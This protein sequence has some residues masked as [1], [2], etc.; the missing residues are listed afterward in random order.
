MSFFKIYALIMKEILHFNLAKQ[1]R[2]L[3]AFSLF[4]MLGL[5]ANAQVVAT[6]EATNPT[7]GGFTNGSITAIG[8]GG[9]APYTYEWS[10]GETTESIYGLG[11]GT[12]SVTITDMDLGYDVATVTLT[13]APQTDADIIISDICSGNGNVTVPTSGGVPPYVY[14]WSD[15]GSGDT[16]TGLLAGTQYC[17]T[18]LDANVCGVVTCVVIPEAINLT[19]V[20]SDIACSAG[21]D[22]S[23]TAI[24]TGGTAPYDVLWD[25]GETS[26]VNA[27]LPV[28]TYFVT[29]TDGNGC[30]VSGSGTVGSPSAIDLAVSVTSPPCGDNTMG[31]AS[32][33]P[34]GGT[35]NYSY[36]WSTGATTQS[37]SGLSAGTY[38]VTV[39]DSQGCQASTDVVIE[40]SSQVD[41]SINSNNP[42]CAAPN[43]GSATATGSNGTAPYTYEWNTGATTQTITN[44]GAGLYTVMVTD[45]T[46][47]TNAA[48]VTLTQEGA[49]IFASTTQVNASCGANNGSATAQGSGGS[50]SYSYS[51]SNG[52]NTQTISNLAPGTYTVTV[53]DNNSGCMGAKTIFITGTDDVDVFVSTMN[54]LCSSNNGNAMASPS[55]GTAPYTYA[56]SNGGNTQVITGLAPGTYTVTVTDANGCTAVDSDT[57]GQTGSDVNVTAMATPVS[58]FGENTG[59][60]GT[61][62]SGGATPYSFSWS[63]GATSSTLSNLTAGTYNVTVT[64]ANGCTATASATVIQP[65]QLNV[66]ASST[67]VACAGGNTGSASANVTGGTSGYSYS[68][69][70][71]GNTQTISNLSA[72][73]YTVTVTDANGCT[74]TSSTT[75]GQGG[76]ITLSPGSTD[77]SC[78]GGNDGTA[79]VNAFGGTSPYNYAWSNGG[80]SQM[81]TGLSA[82]TY[83][84]TVTDVNG[85]TATA[86]TTISQPTQ[87]NV[88]ANSTASACAGANTGTAT[89]SSSGGSAPYTYAWSNGG[90]GAT[91]TGLSAGTYTVTATDSNG[92][93]DTSSTTVSQGNGINVNA[94]STASACAGAS[95]GTAT[96]NA[97]GGS[98]PYTYAWSNGGNNATITGLSAGTYTVTVTDANG[99][100]NIDATTVTQG[101]DLDVTTNATTVSCPGGINGTAT[102]NASGGSSPY[103]Y[104]W[105]NGGSGSSISG[106]TNGTYTVTATDANGCTGVSTATVGVSNNPSLSCSVTVSSP[107]SENNGSD[108]ALTVAVSNGSGNYS[109]AWSNGA[110]AQNIN[111]LSPGTYTVTVTDNTTG[112]TTTCS[113]TLA[114]PPECECDNFTDP[115][116]IC[117]DQTACGT[118]YDPAPIT[119]LVNPSGGSGGPI[120]Y[121]WMFKEGEGPFN[122][123]QVT[124]I[125]NT[126]SLTYDPPA[127]YTTTTYYRCARRGPCCPFIETT[128]ITIFINEDADASFTGPADNIL[129]QG[130]TYTYTANTNSSTAT[131]S[132]N[133]QGSA[134]V[135]GENTSSIEVVWS[136]NGFYDVMLTVTDNACT[137]STVDNRLVTNSTDFCGS[138][139]QGGGAQGLVIDATVV[140]SANVEVELLTEEGSTQGVTY[141]LERSKDG[142]DFEEINTVE[143]NSLTYNQTND[144]DPMR[145]RSFYRVS[146][147]NE[148]GVVS[149]SNTEEITIFIGNENTLIYPNP[150]RGEIHYEILDTF[151]EDVTLEVIAADGRVI[152]TY[153][154]DKDTFQVTV[155][156]TDLPSGMYFMRFN[157]SSLGV[158]TVKMM[159]Q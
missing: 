91:I 87:V 109:Y 148:A 18:V 35:P 41:I 143:M 58:C 10:N 129:C 104:A 145:G 110:N 71:G 54:A 96:A 92:C 27:N 146:M 51:W 28:G 131:Y 155:N 157:F 116:Q 156:T 19:V 29:V 75:I 42:T 127:L 119:S 115:G 1:G 55:N 136:S 13:S 16:R 102:A 140:H 6:V 88:S 12:Y 94:S 4:L 11:P 79:S 147:T 56:W 26:T 53:T 154:S 123:T 31:A 61:S 142:V 82:G 80:N 7:C 76:A 66:N 141:V 122:Q 120:E 65:S 39:T 9:W 62:T 132:W 25:N 113:N 125:P 111:S 38:S 43:G 99:C 135:T 67:P 8:S 23:V 64:D 24:I 78:F 70:N 72:G 95:T 100:S 117:C 130:E 98:S 138:E 121:V 86:S 15:G 134:V 144:L 108:G 44:L 30:T 5:T 20:G 118:G 93:T 124:E 128:G 36:L 46:G 45:A 152:R 149:Y 34:S 14:N 33:N 52:A 151:G 112:C 89:A 21:C 133:V 49:S 74:D 69:S 126:N 83:S 32:V 103:T 81:I 90:N 40:P 50:G 159:K 22:G 63:N 137:A 3:V 84:V 150:F 97:S 139:A 73:N 57:V 37:V 2:L 68:W 77:V 107:V 48:S 105:S 106:V 47:C 158:Q 153:V 60:V 59:A 114:N 101:S 17:V 85:C